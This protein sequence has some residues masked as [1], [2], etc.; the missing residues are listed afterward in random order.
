MVFFQAEVIPD[1]RLCLTMPEVSISLVGMD[2]NTLI[3]F[4]AVYSGSD[5]NVCVHIWAFNDLVSC[6]KRSILEAL[7]LEVKLTLYFYAFYG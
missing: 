4:A 6:R 2:R 7:V 1:S 3:R 5:S